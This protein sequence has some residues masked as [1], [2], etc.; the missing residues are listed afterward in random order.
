MKGHELSDGVATRQ[1]GHHLCVS[2]TPM[3]YALLRRL[4]LCVWS[5]HNYQQVFI[6]A[7]NTACQG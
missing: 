2:T 5:H 7:D 6:N 4:S 1:L 3:M